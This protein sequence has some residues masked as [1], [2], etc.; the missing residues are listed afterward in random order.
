MFD[1]R[2]YGTCTIG[3]KSDAKDDIR[4]EPQ[5][6]SRS[7]S[8]KHL[9]VMPLKTLFSISILSSKM[10]LA[11]LDVSASL[12]RSAYAS[13]PSVAATLHWWMR[14]SIAC[15]WDPDQTESPN[16]AIQP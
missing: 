6:F 1:V 14:L 13:I 11:C 9:R 8:L 10:Y 7:V 4:R 5:V 2:S 15:R 12:E 3:P 16:T